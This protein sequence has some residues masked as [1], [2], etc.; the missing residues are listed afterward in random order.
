MIGFPK[1]YLVLIY[2]I[3]FL[4]GFEILEGNSRPKPQGQG[5]QTRQLACLMEIFHLFYIV[6][7]NQNNLSYQRGFILLYGLYCFGTLDYG[8]G[9]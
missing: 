1:P 2:S 9:K 3:S 8:R 5:V 6:V 7:D 4:G